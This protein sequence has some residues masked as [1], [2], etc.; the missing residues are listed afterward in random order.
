MYVKTVEILLYLLA[1]ATLGGETRN[2]NDPI[3]VTPPKVTKA[4]S[5]AALNFAN[6]NAA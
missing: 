1:L 5:H 2:R 6:E 3:S 4:S